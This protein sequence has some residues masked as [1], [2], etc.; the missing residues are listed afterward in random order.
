MK[1]DGLKKRDAYYSH[2]IN[3]DQTGSNNIS[4]KQRDNTDQPSETT[5]E[6]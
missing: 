5:P 6:L 2:Y 4:S 3:N 1:K